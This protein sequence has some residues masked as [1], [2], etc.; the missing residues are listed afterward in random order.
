MNRIPDLLEFCEGLGFNFELTGET[1]ELDFPV[2]WKQLA[3]A[4]QP[5]Q[6]HLLERLKTRAAMNAQ[7]CIGGPA[8]GRRHRKCP[9]ELYPYHEAH[10]RW[11]VYLVLKDWTAPFR[12]YASSLP[13]ARRMAKIAWAEYC[14]GF[15][16]E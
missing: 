9:G 13:Q 5:F 1:F 3:E 12:G 4:I 11:A 14:R 2:Q 8:D 7:S 6:K 15:G 16:R 10:G